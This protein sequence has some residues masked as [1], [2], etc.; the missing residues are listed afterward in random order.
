MH[1]S[2]CKLC[3]F[4]DQVK[5]FGKTASVTQIR[6]APKTFRYNSFFTTMQVQ[7]YNPDTDLW[8][9]KSSLPRPFTFIT[10]AALNGIIYVVGKLI[11][12]CIFCYGLIIACYFATSLFIILMFYFVQTDSNSDL[13]GVRVYRTST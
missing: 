5:P 9:V 1:H 12:F 11:Y 13:S 8:S 4:C 7:V 3:I 10:A 6:T 2:L